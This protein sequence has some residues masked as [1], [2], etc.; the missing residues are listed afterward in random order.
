MY[1][2]VKGMHV[3]TNGMRECS[4]YLMGEEHM[5]VAKMDGAI[6]ELYTTM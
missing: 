3:V 2:R 6:F 1:D 5:S 4:V